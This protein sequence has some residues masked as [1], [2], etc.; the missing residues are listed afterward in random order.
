MQFFEIEIDY[1]ILS[2]V[3]KWS[4]NGH[5]MVIQWS[6]NCHSS[7]QSLRVAQCFTPCN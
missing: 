3:I 7:C 6:F 4:L 1:G 5:S 2:E